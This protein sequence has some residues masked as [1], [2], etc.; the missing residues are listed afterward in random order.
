MARIPKKIKK[1]ARRVYAKTGLVNPMK[2]GK[3]STT[4]L[5]KDVNMLK[6]MLNSE[7]KRV[8]QTNRD[9]AVGQLA[10]ATGSGHFL[11][12]VTPLP[13]QGTGYNQKTGNSIKVNSTHIDFQIAGQLNNISGCKLK[14]QL[15]QVIGQ[16]FVTL[17]DILGKFIM[18]NSFAS[19][20]TIYDIN[21]S[22]DPDYFKN[23]RVV[24]QKIVTLPVDQITGD[25]PVKQFSMGCKY[26]EFHVRTNDNDPT[27]SMGQLFLIITA[28]RGNIGGTNSTVSGVPIVQSGTGCNFGYE[29]THYFYDN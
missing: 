20:G 13:S 25:I 27:L 22:R 7:K 9:Q 16:P 21:G 4:R 10:N 26:K 14:F 6:K 1:F 11:L 2:K 24:A 15:V 18:P 5:I 3:L 8:I 19:G 17:T 28:D 23:F 29:I 12:D